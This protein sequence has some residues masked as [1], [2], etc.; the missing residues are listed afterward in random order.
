MIK[1]SE[2]TGA[3]S[4]DGS[5]LSYE[6]IFYES[7]SINVS[8]LVLV[9]EFTNQDGPHLSDHFLVLVDSDRRL[10]EVPIGATGF[11]ST[12]KQLAQMLGVNPELS[13]VGETDFASGILWPEFFRGRHVF[14]YVEKPSRS[15][16]GRLFF[17]FGVGRIESKLSEHL[18]EYLNQK[19][20]SQTSAKR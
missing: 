7:W 5:L 12:W 19:G 3:L 1:I 20:T 11:E 10:Y 17:P 8:A 18:E 13:L 4:F 16:F 2:D 15:F 6:S 14:D 9:G